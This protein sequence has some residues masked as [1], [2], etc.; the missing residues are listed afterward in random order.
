MIVSEKR[1]KIILTTMKFYF[2]K[3]HFDV[4]FIRLMRRYYLSFKNVKLK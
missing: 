4:H 2:K 1:C 3:K